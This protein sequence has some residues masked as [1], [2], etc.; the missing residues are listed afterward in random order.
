MRQ[1]PNRPDLDAVTQK[2]LSAA[3]KAI[4][5]ADDPKAVAEKKCESARQ[6]KWFKP[7]TAALKQLAGPGERC[8]WCSGSESS[9]VEHY[10]PKSEF[11]NAAMSWTNFLWSCGLCNQHKGSRFPPQ[12]EPGGQLVN[13]LEDNVWD[14]F[15]IDQFGHLSPRWDVAANG[16]DPRAAKT[17]EILKLSNPEERQALIT[18]RRERRRDLVKQVKRAAQAFERGELTT[19]D[20]R[21]ELADWIAQPYQLDVADYFLNGP[22]REEEPFRAFF[23]IIDGA[24]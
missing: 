23:G 15:Y 8:M 4:E 2:K 19:E 24:T 10:R 1:L 17:V 11:P 7:V 22:G 16:L 9:Q 20:L 3:T 13:P 12:T 21:E 14:F 18:S 5:S 6:A